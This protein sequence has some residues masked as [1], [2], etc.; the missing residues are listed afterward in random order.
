MTAAPES[1]GTRHSKLT[2]G[3]AFSLGLSV[4]Y[5][6]QMPEVNLDRKVSR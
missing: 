3:Y 4:A 2:R 5:G 1:F 6:G